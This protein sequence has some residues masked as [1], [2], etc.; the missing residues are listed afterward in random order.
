APNSRATFVAVSASRVELILSINPFM[1]SLPSTSFA[2]M[3]SLSARSFTVMPSARVIVRETGGGSAGIDGAIERT[4]GSLRWAVGR[5]P[6][7]D[8][9]I[10]GRIGAPGR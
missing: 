2:R 3:P 4:T 9:R 6:D 8:G 5:G 1:R 7:V 10:G